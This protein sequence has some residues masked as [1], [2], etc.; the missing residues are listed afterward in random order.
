MSDPKTEQALTRHTMKPGG[1]YNWKNQ[2]ERLVYLGRY[3][4]WH[5]FR[6]IGD[7]R[8]VWCEVLDADLHML[9]ETRV[10]PQAA[11]APQPA[12]LVRDVAEMLG[13]DSSVPICKA[14]VALGYPPRSVNMA[15]TPA[16]AVAV[17]KHL[18]APAPEPIGPSHALAVRAVEE[19]AQLGY[20]V[21]D[22]LLYPPEPSAQGEPVAFDRM[23][24]RAIVQQAYLA[25][26]ELQGPGFLIGGVMHYRIG[27]ILPKLNE[28]IDTLASA[29]S[30]PPPGVVEAVP[31]TDERIDSLRGLD[32]AGR[33]RFYEHD[34]YVLSNFSAFTLVWKGIRFD[35]SEA[36]YHWEKFDGCDQ[37]VQDMILEAPSAH[38]AFKIAESQ[39]IVRRADWDEIKVDVMHRILR[40]KAEQHEYVRRKLLATGDRELVEDSWRDDFWGWGP[41]RDG[42]NMLGRLWMQVRSELRGIA[43]KAAQEP[44]HG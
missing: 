2:P 9:E 12:F 42:K 24:V 6:K 10:A 4:G 32:T 36:A 18:A 17:A 15:V 35:T 25:L 22:D 7:P 33:V 41:N 30:T 27:L 20:T 23:E 5:Q 34:F 28:A 13:I 26:E 1:R 14:L 8:D 3:G 29:P 16:E 39:R 44:G 31:L 21:K 11:P 43:P 19:L 40:S 38:A 37:E